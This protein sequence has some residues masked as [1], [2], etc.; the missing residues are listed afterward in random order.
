[1][2]HSILTVD[3]SPS[4]RQAVAACLRT[5][6]HRV[7]EAGDGCEALELAAAERFDLVVTDLNMPR[8][9]GLGLIAALRAR[10]DYRSVPI[11]MLTTESSDAMKALGR[12]AGATG[13][14][15]KPFDPRRLLDM[16]ARLLAREV[17]RGAP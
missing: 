1:M 3:D 12:E 16:T 15:V 9:D 17:A 10:P 14:L 8:L 2:T 11:L 4:I 5:A 7:V 13:W 6:G